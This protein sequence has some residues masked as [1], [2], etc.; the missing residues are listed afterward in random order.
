[1]NKSVR[2]N[3]APVVIGA[4]LVQFTVIGGVFAY[5][6]FFSVLET[7]LGWSRSTLSACTSLAFFVMGLLAISAGRLSDRFGP[8]WVL[9]STGIIYGCGYALLSTI[10]EPWHAIALFGLAIGI[11]PWLKWVPLAG[12]SLCH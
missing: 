3:R 4:S 12:K 2:R 9:A 10:N 7:E 5:G 1:M 6:V 11:G 8:R